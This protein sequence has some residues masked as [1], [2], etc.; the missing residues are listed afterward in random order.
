MDS[1][2]QRREAT[3]K[4]LKAMSHPLRA[5]VLMILTERSASPAEMAGE[6][7]ASVPRVS[8]HTKRLVELGCAELV[9][10]EKAPGTGAIAHFYRATERH[11]IDTDEWE[12][13]N[14]LM[15]EGVL[16]EIV[17][18]ML[19]DFVQSARAGIV[20]A[21]ENFA[22]VRTLHVLDREGLQEALD[23]QEQARLGILEAQARSA[24]RLVASGEA[25]AH[26]STWHGCFE[27][28]AAG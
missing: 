5:E 22:L 15:G 24:E 4:R 28:P 12:E 14:S 23:I 26:V 7:G 27:V 17:Q 25:P 8:H 21:D 13:F 3:H 16:G 18:A 10:E 19:D 11:L 9:R 20:G 6:L 2:A 1:K